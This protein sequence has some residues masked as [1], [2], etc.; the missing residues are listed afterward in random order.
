MRVVNLN[1]KIS[2]SD[3]AFAK[4]KSKGK[5]QKKKI[6]FL[7]KNLDQL[8]P[9]VARLTRVQGELLSLDVS[10]GFER[11]LS[12]DQTKE[13]LADVLSIRHPQD[14]RI[15]SPIAKELTVTP[16]SSSLEFPSNDVPSS[17]VAIFGQ[18]DEWVNAMVDMPNNEIVDGAGNHKLGE[19]FVQGISHVV[20]RSERV[21]SNPNDVVVALS[22]G[23]KDSGSLP[24]PSV[25]EEAV[26]A[27]SKI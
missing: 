20:P 15:S 25:T 8:N 22:A 3:A 4:V 17:A 23:E 26:V 16:I 27:P 19:V 10:D 7:T 1:D 6:K 18:N 21:S 13:E 9:E 24:S 12:V 5:E 11:G 14:T 2:S